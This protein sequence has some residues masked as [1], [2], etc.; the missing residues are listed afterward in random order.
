MFYGE[1]YIKHDPSNEALMALGSEELIAAVRDLMNKQHEVLYYG[2]QD[3]NQVKASI[4]ECHKAA[5]VLAPLEKSHPEDAADGPEQRRAGP[6]RC[7]PLYYSAVFEPRRG[8]RRKN[9]PEITPTTSISAEHEL[10][11]LPGDARG[12]RSGL[13]GPGMARNP[14]PCR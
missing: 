1:E 14:L 12:L 11:L 4:A 10:H 5:E 13:H 7:Q 9:E 3:E 8:V 6:V 2:P